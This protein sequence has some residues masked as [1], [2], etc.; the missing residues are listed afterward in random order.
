MRLFL[1]SYK[2][3]QC[4]YNSSLAVNLKI[5]DMISVSTVGKEADSSSLVGN[6]NNQIIIHRRSK[7]LGFMLILCWRRPPYPDFR[8][9]VR[10][11][12]PHKCNQC[13]YTFSLAEDTNYDMR[14]WPI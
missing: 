14:A 10:L 7:K 11:F 9:G 3:N 12:P 4:Q 5:H 13:E 2:C 8:D 1:L 6:P